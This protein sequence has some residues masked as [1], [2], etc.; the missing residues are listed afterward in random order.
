MDEKKKPLHPPS[1][2]RFYPQSDEDLGVGKSDISDADVGRHYARYRNVVAM[3]RKH[4][5]IE[6]GAWIADIGS[7]AGYGTNIL[8]MHFGEHVFGIEPNDTARAYAQAHYKDC[9]FWNDA[10]RD[11]EVCVFVETMEHMSPAGFRS[12]LKKAQVVVVTTPLCRDQNNT[13]HITPF[14]SKEDVRAYLAKWKYEPIGERIDLAVKF[15][16]GDVGDQYIGV[17]KGSSR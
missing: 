3:I 10:P 11:A 2:E 1:L 4:A 14:K 6:D 12:Y 15:T 9:T 5:T 8:R 17:F 7:G 13:W 16:T